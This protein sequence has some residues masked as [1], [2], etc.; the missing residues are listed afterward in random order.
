MAMNL[1]AP[2]LNNTFLKGRAHQL[3]HPPRCV[4]L[5]RPAR[6][7]PCMAISKK[8]LVAKVADKTEISVKDVGPI[9][10]ATLEV[11]SESLLI[12]EK[13]SLIGFGTFEARTRKAR[14]GRNPRTGEPLDIP[15]S[16]IP[17]F[18]AGK[19]FKDAMKAAPK[20]E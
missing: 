15:E 16:R 8:E 5:G 13:V 20:P 17:A 9:I 10:N 2:A 18:S 6:S 12:G 19:A 3:Q 11:I 4:S 1:K 14:T 7:A